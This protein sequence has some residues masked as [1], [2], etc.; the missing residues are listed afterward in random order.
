MPATDDPETLATLSAM[1]GAPP[2][3]PKPGATGS[4][5]PTEAAARLSHLIRSGAY[6]EALDEPLARMLLTAADTDSSGAAE[7][8]RAY[9]MVSSM[10]D[11]AAAAAAGEAIIAVGAAALCLFVHANWAG[12]PVCRSLSAECAHAEARD[13]AALEALTVD[14][15]RAYALLDAPRLLCAARALLIQTLDELQTAQPIIAPWWA[16]RCAI[17]Q[18]RCLEAAAPSLE[19]LA[20]RGMRDALDALAAMPAQLE[21][22][23]HAEVGAAV[24]APATDPVAQDSVEAGSDAEG[25]AKAAKIDRWAPGV[26]VM[27]VGLEGRPELNGQRGVIVG[28]YDETKGRY[29]VQLGSGGPPMLLKPDSLATVAEAATAPSC[30]S[31]GMA[32]TWRDARALAHL[33]SAAC[34]LLHKRSSAC[35]NQI[36]FAKAALGIDFEL[37]GALGKR[38]KHQQTALSQLVLS[39]RRVAEHAPLRG[40]VEVGAEGEAAEKEAAEAALPATVAEEDDELLNKLHLESGEG[41]AGGEGGGAGDYL[42]AGGLRSLEQLAILG[43]CAHVQ[44]TRP[45]AES[46]AEELEPYVTAALALRR[47]WAAVTHALRLKARLESARK[48]RR[49]QS[50]MQLQALVDDVRPAINGEEGTLLSRHLGQTTSGGKAYGDERRKS[51]Q[52]GSDAKWLQSLASPADVSDAAASLSP[53]AMSP[54]RLGSRLR[55]FWAVGLAPRWQLGAELARSMAALGLLTEASALFEQL[56]LW[57]ECVS[58]L[59]VIG[60]AA[61]AERIVRSRLDEVPSPAMWVHLGDLTDDES[62]FEKAWELSGGSYARAKF[63]LG[64]RAMSAE[65]WADARAHLQAALNLKAH[66]S[67]AW[68]CSSVCL[69]K[70]DDTEGALAEMRRVVAIDPSHHQAWSSLGGLLSKKRLKREALFAFREA[71]KLRGDSWQLWQHLTLAALDVGSFEEAT[72]AAA[73]SLSLGGPPAPQVSSLIAQAV[74]R[75]IKDAGADGTRSTRRLLPKARQLLAASSQA[76]PTDALHWDAW[77]HLETQCGGFTEVCECLRS[78]LEAGKQHT[79]WKSEPE[80]LDALSEVAAQLVEKLLESGERAHLKEAKTTVESLLRDASEKLAATPGCESLRMLIARI[81]R[82]DDD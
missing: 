78:R 57:D 59:S 28:S 23:S 64:S 54:S 66:Y 12:A 9:L 79:P 44:L 65:R 72:Y 3:G 41:G 7:R 69:L 2:V 37:A 56:E 40:E 33:E 53:A 5:A 19:R 51:A 82:H 6:A 63:K 4:M 18:Q 50:L 8:A 75:D 25:G 43:A 27:V 55:G 71:C 35:S 39:V 74:A 11:V 22:Q 61:D 46:T 49:H 24:D 76:M 38:T 80:A 58:A 77:L 42:P 70:L 10:E 45:A 68:Y 67:E 52:Q 13:K 26:R 36:D 29:G 21:S 62:C 81:R 47:N 1:L 20:A 16:A 30:W 31:A 73:R 14:G 17:T 60:H 15:E 32:A 48:R 34:D